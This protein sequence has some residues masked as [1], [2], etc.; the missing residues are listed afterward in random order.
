M[1]MK[2]NLL[3]S[4]ITIVFLSFEI[5]SAANLANPATPIPDARIAVGASYHLGGYTLT[6]QELPSLFNRIHARVS[7]SPLKYVSF[8]IDGGTIQIDVERTSD[9]AATFHGK[10]GYSGGGH[11]K[12]ATPAFLKQRLSFVAIGQGTIFKSINKF[13]AEY[14]GKDATGAVGMQ[15]HIPGFGFITAGPWVYLILGQNKSFDGTTSIYSNTNN[16]RGWLAIDYFPKMKELSSNKPYISLEFSI[17]PKANYSERIPVQEFSV[18]VSIG[19]I[20]DRLY[21]T[22]SEVEWSP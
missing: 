15:V 3:Y 5:S 2:T 14:A 7:Y 9:S 4:C 20:T 12:L 19:S 10:F 8:G 11:L 13:S 22:Q 1:R 6:N 17:S 21:G 18:S 16:V